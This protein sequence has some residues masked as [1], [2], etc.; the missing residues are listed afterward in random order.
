MRGRSDRRRPSWVVMTGLLALVGALAAIGVVVGLARHRSTSGQGASNRSRSER[1]ATTTPA[2]CMAGAE[3]PRTNVTAATVNASGQPVGALP[4][5]TTAYPIPPGALFVSTVGDDRAPA[6]RLAPVRSVQ[7]AVDIASPG[8]TIVL[9]AGV[10]RERVDIPP[11]K[12]LTLESYPGEVVWFS[13]S[14]AVSNWTPHAGAWRA[15]GWTARFNHEGLDPPLLIGAD[16]RTGYPD[17]A[18]LDGRPLHQV[19][20]RADVVPGTF[21]VDESTS[22]L[23]VGSNPLGHMLEASVLSEALNVQAPGSIVRGLG[24][25]HYATSVPDGGA[26]RGWQGVLFE[27]DVFTNNAA[28]G[29]SLRGADTVR[30]ITSTFNGQ[31]GIH[32]HMA[33]GSVI[34][35]SVTS[36]NNTDR[37][38]PEAAA[39]GIKLTASTNVTLRGNVAEDNYGHAL[40]LDEGSDHAIVA[41][42]LPRRNE[43]GAGVMFEL[44]SFGIIAGNISTDNQVGIQA[45][46]ASHV[47]VWNNTLVNNETGIS[48]YDDARPLRPVDTTIRNN[49]VSAGPRSK[50]LL[51]NADVSYTRTWKDMA[52]TSDHNAFYRPCTTATGD[53]SSLANGAAG[54]LLYRT[55]RSQAAASAQ[56]R[57]SLETDNTATDPYVSD[58]GRDN[59]R[60]I[61]GSPANGAGT[62]W[63]ADIA[64]ALGLPAAHRVDIGAPVG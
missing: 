14:R 64:L 23:F 12:A 54:P 58:A 60:T 10:Y 30:R 29:L 57:H 7:H 46:E 56:E 61:V 1:P 27:N 49:I 59:Y 6:S 28:A 25:M 24:F 34:K 19:A 51:I 40:W 33:S 22:Q 4:L 15:D 3:T 38:N 50:T 8:S 52:W 35:D 45:G 42:N 17:M 5:G 9:R 31:L 26:V 44:S 63:P 48:A 39:G 55:V 18:F 47:Q 20:T 36:S 41:R 53:I 32:G 21:F 62:P 11:A 43:R 37:F 16:P 13:G 2:S